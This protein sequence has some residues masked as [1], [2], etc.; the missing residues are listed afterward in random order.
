[1]DGSNKH[2]PKVSVLTEANLSSAG[3]FDVVLPLPGHDIEYPK[4]EIGMWFE[5]LLHKDG[6]SSAKL[7]QTVK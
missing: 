1:M 2:R 5:E 3:I 7:K 6:L 4:N